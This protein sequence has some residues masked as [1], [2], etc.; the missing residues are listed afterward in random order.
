[1]GGSKL[2]FAKRACKK[3]VK[4]LSPGDTLHFITY[5]DKVRTTFENGDLSEAGKESMKAQI[6]GIRAGA[7]TNLYGGL[8]RAAALLGSRADFIGVHTDTDTGY[9]SDTNSDASSDAGVHGLAVPKERTNS[10]SHTRKTLVNLDSHTNP[11]TGVRRIFLFSDGCVNVGI[12]DP[13]EIKRRVKAWAEEGI[14]T[15]TFGIGSD[16]DEPL[17]RGIAESGK[18]RYTF[19]ASAHD[20]PRL[21]S[22]SIH[23]LLKLYGS[24]ASIDIRGGAHTT[25]AKVYRGDDEDEGSGDATVSGLLQLGDLHSANE[26]MILLELDSAPPGDYVDGLEY[27][28]AEW[29]LDFQRNGAP[30]QFS[31]FVNLSAVKQRAT[32]GNEAASVQAMFAIRRSSDMD[33][34]IAQFLSNR[35]QVRAKDMKSRQV[36]LLKETL[37]I[38]RNASESDPVDIEALEAVLRRAETVAERLDTGED[39]EI[40]RRHCVQEMELC[41]AMSVGAFSDGCDSSDGEGEL[42]DANGPGARNLRRRLRDFDDSDNSPPSSP[43]SNHWPQSRW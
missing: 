6:D 24:E 5:D 36:S 38:V 35:D 40:V 26:R 11:D 39:M 15:T 17:M 3:L 43:R 14:T 30:V 19:L 42:H 20:I 31:G 34:E 29:F 33:S 21:V 37:E 13:H 4:H 28:A 23:D 25:V 32:L 10:D 9:N 18:G 22:K 16:F 2:D 12:T 7:T 41:R 1:M 27:R 8:E